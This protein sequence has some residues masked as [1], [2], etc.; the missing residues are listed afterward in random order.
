M[1]TDTPLTAL[2]RGKTLSLI[3][4]IVLLIAGLTAGSRLWGFIGL[5]VLVGA[6]WAVYS[7]TRAKAA[8]ESGPWPW[9]A[10]FRAQAESM[11][12]P[13]DPTPRRVV[14]PDEMASEIAH[15]A[16]TQE[17]LARLIADKPPAWPW[18]AFT[19]VLV[20]RRNALQ[21][22]LRVVASGYQPRPGIVPLSGRT[23]AAVAYHAMRAIADTAVQA[24]QFLFSPALKG[25]FGNAGGPHSPDAEPDA[26]AILA[27]AHRLMDYHGAFLGQA[28]TCL[29]TPVDSEARDFVEDMGSFAIS[30]LVGYEKFIATMCARIGEAQELLPYTDKDDFI[31]LGEAQL[32]TTVCDELLERTV[33]HVKRFTD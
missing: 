5:M 13:I 15:V 8:P 4:G 21:V 27:V 6:A 14:P 24:E 28:E 22:R 31:E 30:P 29:Q 20:Q 25:A 1:S 18:A 12:R 3:A 23:Y 17:A 7:G 26:D 10:D 2:S 19:S 9:P 32:D 11:A 33:A 16:T